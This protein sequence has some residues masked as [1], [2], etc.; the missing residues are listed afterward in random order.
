MEHLKI[1]FIGLGQRGEW[2]MKNVL[3]NLGIKRKSKNDININTISER[4]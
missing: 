4:N 2:L 1:G 3:N